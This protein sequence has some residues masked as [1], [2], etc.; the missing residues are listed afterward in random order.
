MLITSRTPTI[1]L[2]HLLI[3][4]AYS[5]FPQPTPSIN[6]SISA[7]LKAATAPKKSKDPRA[8]RRKEKEKQRRE[9]TEAEIIADLERMLA[10]QRQ[11]PD[12]DVWA[13]PIETMGA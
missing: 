7:A 13:Q 12:I 2:R 4:R 11:R 6:P 3:F 5:Q 8:E 1:R 10:V 9:R